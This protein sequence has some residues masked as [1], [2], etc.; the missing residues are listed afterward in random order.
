MERA[1]EQLARRVNEFREKIAESQAGGRV[2]ADYSLGMVNALIFCDHLINL[3]DGQPKFF[4]RTSMQIGNLPKPVAI[5]DGRFE[6]YMG[7]DKVYESLKD[8]VLLAARN[9]HGSSGPGDAGSKEKLQ[10]AITKL[11]G[12]LD[13]MEKL[14]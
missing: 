12:F 13:Q 8:D 10:A 9:V 6:E 1:K 3:R 5:Q 11:D 4:D 7:G 14:R 2:P